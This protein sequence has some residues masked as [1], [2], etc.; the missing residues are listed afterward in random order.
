MFGHRTTSFKVVHAESGPRAAAQFGRQ[1]ASYKIYAIEDH[2]RRQQAVQ[3]VESSVWV[4]VAS[5]RLDV[6]VCACG[7]M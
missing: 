4:A 3:R 2:C 6:I 1:R 7:I 5:T